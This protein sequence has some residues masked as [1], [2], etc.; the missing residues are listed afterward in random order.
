MVNVWLKPC[1]KAVA[2]LPFRLEGEGRGGGPKKTNGQSR[3]CHAN[4][5]LRPFEEVNMFS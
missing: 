4:K 5:A 3:T 1:K 2:K